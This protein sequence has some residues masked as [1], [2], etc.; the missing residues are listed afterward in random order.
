[1]EDQIIYEQPLN[2]KMRLFLRLEH[3]F[4]QT[5]FTLRGS[6]EWDS[7]ATLSGI[8]GVLEIL[9]RFDV[10][11]DLLKE[12]E[13][14]FAALSPLRQN[15]GVDNERL[16][17]VLKQIETHRTQLHETSGQLDQPLR[18]IE[19]LNNLMQRGTMVAGNCN[20]DLP[21][22]H[23]WL[24]QPP[25]KRIALLEQWVNALAIVREP[26]DLILRIIREGTAPVSKIAEQGF[27]QQTLDTSIPYQIIR[28]IL[29][30][31]T[32]YYAEISAGKQRFSIRFL[33]PLERE[34]TSQYYDD[35]TFE[36]CCCGL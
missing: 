1:M 18:E 27:Y 15:P 4:R 12:L 14:D 5:T 2:E 28:V 24:Q 6:S 13:R 11:T 17:R 10:K 20:F 7:R 8:I 36:L 21:A 31:E 34:R 25:E 23:H 22:Y 29:S 3:L 33:Q 32:D 26:I 30:L 9:S 35:V 16:D 19:L